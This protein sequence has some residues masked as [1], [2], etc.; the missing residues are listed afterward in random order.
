MWIFSKSCYTFCDIDKTPFFVTKFRM[1]WDPRLCKIKPN[2]YYEKYSPSNY[3]LEFW[4][5]CCR[6]KFLTKIRPSPG[7]YHQ[8]TKN[9]TILLQKFLPATKILFLKSLRSEV[10][11]CTLIW[12]VWPNFRLYV[13]F[14]KYAFLSLRNFTTNLRFLLKK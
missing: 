9:D 8:K 3:V 1:E 11:F 10:V 5:I 2:R 6:R 7:F 13:A 14:W 4:K 12:I